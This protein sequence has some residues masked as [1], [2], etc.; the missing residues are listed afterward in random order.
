MAVA[1]DRDLDAVA[2]GLRA[3][4][5][6]PARWYADPAQDEREPERI[7]RRS[8][9]YAGRAEQVAEPGSYLV[10]EAGPVPRRRR[11]RP[12]GRRCARS[13]TCAATA[14]IPV[15][16]G[17]GRCTTLQC[18]Y[19]AW[20]YDLDG[21]PAQDPARRPRAG[22]RSG[23][24][25]AAPGVRRDVGPVGVR[26]RRSGR[27]AAG[28]RPRRAAR[29]ARRLRRRPRP[30]RVP[31]PRAVGARVQLEGGGRELPRVLPLPGRA[32]R[33]LEG[34]RR[35]RRRLPARARIRRSR[36]R[37]ASRATR[38]TAARSPGRSSTGC[39]RTSRST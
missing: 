27:R 3:G 32:P 4:H 17:A 35:E 24:A 11:A 14:A 1:D 12:R 31:P 16:A 30:R 37:P 26:P 2:A 28:G 23:R 33:P 5:S 38:P 13:S 15:L 29:G 20:T 9:Q 18:P 7:F 25:R 19:H 39:G 36:S 21:A 22:P 34:D 10:A 8:W 6:L